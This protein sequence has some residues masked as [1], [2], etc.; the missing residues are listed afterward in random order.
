M[1][2]QRCE[3]VSVSIMKPGFL[4]LLLVVGL[5]SAGCGKLKKKEPPPPKPDPLAVPEIVDEVASSAPAPAPIDPAVPALTINKSAQVS[6]LGYHNFITGKSKEQMQI[7]ID[8]FRS[9]MQALKDAKLPVIPMKDFLAWRRGEKDIPDPSIVI[10]ID[11]GWKA[12]HTL[13]LPVLKEF[14]YP[15]I[16][17]CYKNFVNLGGK[18]LTT[19]EIK[20]LMAGGGEIGCHSVSH[21]YK[22]KIN[23]M[24]LKSQDTG[25]KFLSKEMKDSKQFL[26]DLLGLKVTTYAYP[27]GYFS[28]REEEVGREAGYEAMFTVAPAKVTWDTPVTAL[29]RYI[30][31]G[32]DPEDRYFKLAVSFRGTADGAM[33]KQLL[34]GE[35]NDEPL[36]VTTP[37]PNAIVSSRRPLIEVDVAKLEGIDPASIVMKI[38]GFGPVPAAF[39][40][41]GKVIRYQL[42]ESLR[43]KD[44]HVFV[45]FRRNSEPKPDMVSWR[46]SIDIDSHYL[47]EPPV[48]LEKAQPIEEM[49]P[50]EEEQAVT[51]D[52]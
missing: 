4:H 9:H 37:L 11:D 46:F 48:K 41:A 30:I 24:F 42:N 2:G 35:G 45:T 36:V 50:P 29:G 18:S 6:V 40:A 20:E 16:I 33:V 19:A 23:S 44:C 26:E 15:F 34:G 52:R 10:T 39:D 51:E 13:A 28:P 43:A 38:A 8:H 5:C 12:T 21:P 17:F 7:N 25:E 49:E 47:P 31:L 27:G 3:V 1:G 22:S 32:N 14:G